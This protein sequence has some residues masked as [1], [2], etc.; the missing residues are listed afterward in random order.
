MRQQI[1][2]EAAGTWLSS[3]FQNFFE[4]NDAGWDLETASGRQTE[5]SWLPLRGRSLDS[6]VTFKDPLKSL[7]LTQLCLC[8]GSSVGSV[9]IVGH[10]Q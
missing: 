2:S 6:K 3:W 7:P 9:V 5:K 1:G 4:M 8:L 10:M